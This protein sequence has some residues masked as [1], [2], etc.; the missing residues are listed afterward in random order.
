MR[1]ILFFHLS[2]DGRF[3]C[4]HIL[5]FVNSIPVTA[6]AHVSF[7]IVV[8]LGHVP[9]SGL[10]GLYGTPIFSFFRKLRTLLSIAA[11]PAYIPTNACLRIESN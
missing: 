7:G 6:G 8:F 11:P 1:R 10:A 5:A 2:A 9:S 4:F 3:G